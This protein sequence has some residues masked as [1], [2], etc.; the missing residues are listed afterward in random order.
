MYCLIFVKANLI[1]KNFHIDIRINI[2][3]LILKLREVIIHTGLSR[4]HI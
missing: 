4:L 3:L 2:E 1:N